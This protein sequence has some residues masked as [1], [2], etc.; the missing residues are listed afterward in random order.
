[1]N[2]HPRPAPADDTVLESLRR[3]VLRGIALNREPGYH[4]AG[5]FLD[6]SYDHV[7][8][9]HTALS[10]DV[11]PHC[12]AEDGQLSLSGFAILADLAMAGAVRAG[13]DPKTRLATVTMNLQFSGVAGT[14][15]LHARGSM[16]GF[17][18]GAAAQQGVSTVAIRNEAGLVCNGAATFMVLKPPRGVEL[19]PVPHRRRGENPT[20]EISG[21]RLRPDEKKVLAAAEASI[22]HVRLHGG[23]FVRHFWGVQAKHVAGGA[24]ATV[25]NG[26]HI[27]NRVGHVQG[28]IL[29]GLAAETAVAALNPRWQ[30]TA[31][32]AWYISPG[33]GRALKLRSRVVHHGRLVAVVRTEVTGKGADGARRKV[34]DLMTTHAWRAE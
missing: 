34:F 1:M 26:P 19:H 25:K 11:A 23:S 29:L 2:K 8:T 27:G 20:P 31:L 21:G 7:G 32:S 18:E 30:L 13:L 6:L 9:D 33:E 17:I 24:E 12:S 16:H 10:V 14:G 15:R 22:A 28:G 3:Q 5:N 4:F